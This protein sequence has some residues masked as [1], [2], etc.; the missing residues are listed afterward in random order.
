VKPGRFQQEMERWRRLERAEE[1]R[2]E[3]ELQAAAR[4]GD[5]ATINRLLP[6]S[7]SAGDVFGPRSLL[8]PQHE[9][10]GP[11]YDGPARSMRARGNRSI[12]NLRK[13]R[14]STAPEIVDDAE[15]RAVLSEFMK[16]LA[17]KGMR[18][19]ELKGIRLYCE[20]NSPETVA[21]M[22]CTHRT[23]VNRWLLKAEKLAKSGEQNKPK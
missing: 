7:P 11:E 13:Q 21:G 22:L 23:T 9:N 19:K 4:S 6:L 5:T 2:Q 10:E 12:L 8:Q 1:Q 17:S 16:T 14:P 18:K 15:R 3:N 20:K